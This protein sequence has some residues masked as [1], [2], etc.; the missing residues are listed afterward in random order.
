[1]STSGS[2]YNAFTQWSTNLNTDLLKYPLIEANIADV[3]AEDPGTTTD[4]AVQFIKAGFDRLGPYEYA[5]R[6][7]FLVNGSGEEFAIQ[8]M[9]FY[10]AFSNSN[11]Y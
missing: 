10:N 4:H 7:G 8:F 9:S 1:M 2:C 3:R 6:H 11:A 5:K